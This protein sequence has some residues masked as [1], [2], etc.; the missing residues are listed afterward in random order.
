MN[1]NYAIGKCLSCAKEIK[2][3]PDGLKSKYFKYC[4]A[5]CHR[6]TGSPCDNTD[7]C[8]DCGELT[9]WKN[10]PKWIRD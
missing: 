1:C 3:T 7:A 4:G 2:D 9:T 5:D 10:Q 6:S 8:P